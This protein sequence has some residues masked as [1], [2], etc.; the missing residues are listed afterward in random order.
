MRSHYIILLTL[1]LLSP[2]LLAANALK[3]NPSPY[4]A[5]HGDDPVDWL[6]FDKDAMER[7]QRDDKLIFMSIG[8]FA[9]HWCHVM[10]REAFS[11]EQIAEQLNAGFVSIKVDRELNPALDDRL[12]RFAQATAGQGGWPLNVFLTPQGFPLFAMTYAPPAEFESV[13]REL[14]ERWKKDRKQLEQAASEVDRK[15]ASI[16]DERDRLRGDIQSKTLQERFIAAA[17]EWA[18][19]LKGGFGQRAK[20][21][22]APQIDALLDAPVDQERTDFLRTTLDSMAT[23]GLRDVVGGGFFR[24]TIDPNWETPHYEKMLYTNA[25]LTSIYLKAARLFDAPAYRAVAFDTLDFA[26]REMQTPEGLFI[27][28]LSAVD[29]ENREGAFYLWQPKQLK[30]ILSQEDLDLV[31]VAWGTDRYEDD[32]VDILPVWKMSPSQVRKAFSLSAQE[33]EKKFKRIRHTLVDYRETTRSLPKDSKR[34]AGWNG[35]MLSAFAT[36][37]GETQRYHKDG[38]RLAKAIRD[39]FWNGQSLIKGLDVESLSYGAGGLEDYA[40]VG[41]GLLDWARATGS[42]RDRAAAVSIIA[43]AWD[44][45]STENGWRQTEASL[46][47]NPLTEHHLRDGPIPSPEAVLLRTTKQLDET[48][49]Q[50][51]DLIERAEGVAR[52]ITTGLIESPYYYGTLIQQMQ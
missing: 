14:K 13:V 37:L 35:L 40:Y 22:S 17:M 26:L 11:D 19:R 6:P 45:F 18:D 36:S 48:N 38:E 24:Y 12:M 4:L 39:N 51:R 50:E 9:C 30:K 7:A 46:L 49:K 3:S 27:G 2:P 34:L 52:Q 32:D 31:N 20:F 8:Y 5:M 33:F 25:L 41:A 21:P 16:G 44:R 47:P 43:A 23:Q 42:A 29:G 10:Q 1:V 28:S 15:L